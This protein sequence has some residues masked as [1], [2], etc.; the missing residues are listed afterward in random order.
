MTGF[1]LG[2]V[3]GLLVGWNFLKQPE[4]VATNVTKL[5]TKLGL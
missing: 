1:I 4:W 5:R 3:V 2:V